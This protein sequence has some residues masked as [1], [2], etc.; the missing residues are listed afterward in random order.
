MVRDQETAGSI[1]VTSTEVDKRN[2]MRYEGSVWDE[3]GNRVPLTER[4]DLSWA[5]WR[6]LWYALYIKPYPE[7]EFGYITKWDWNARWAPHQTR[8]EIEVELHWVRVELDERREARLVQELADIRKAP[9]RQLMEWLKMARRCGGWW[10]PCDSKSEY[11]YKFEDIKAELDT[12]EHIPN[13][14]EA[15][16]LR[17]AAALQHRKNKRRPVAQRQRAAAL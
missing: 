8:T 2:V 5:T 16:A 15:R 3:D 14:K 7:A 6:D 17:R 13:K 1:P 9:T 4:P 12:R 10:S 11:G